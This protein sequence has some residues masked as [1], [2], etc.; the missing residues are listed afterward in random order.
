MTLFLVFFRM[1]F[2]RGILT[3]REE[4]DGQTGRLIDRKKWINR[5][6]G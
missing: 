6:K 1:Y 4:G 2:D 5:E 3:D